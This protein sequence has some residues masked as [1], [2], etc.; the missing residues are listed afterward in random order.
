MMSAISICLKVRNNTTDSNDSIADV[1]ESNT[2][3]KHSVIPPV[4]TDDISRKSG[5]S[6]NSCLTDTEISFNLTKPEAEEIIVQ[7]SFTE[8]QMSDVTADKL[9]GTINEKRM[10]SSSSATPYGSG[11]DSFNGESDEEISFSIPSPLVKPVGSSTPHP[12]TLPR[13]NENIAELE[14]LCNL[15]PTLRLYDPPQYRSKKD[16]KFSKLPPPL[17]YKGISEN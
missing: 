17:T 12:P 15:L 8:R 6:I 10:K 16:L 1:G 5:I 14:E 11:E 13:K 4:D 7:E 2:N 3:H 9:S